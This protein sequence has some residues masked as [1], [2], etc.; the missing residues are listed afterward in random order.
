MAARVFPF[1]RFSGFRNFSGVQNR[2]VRGIVRSDCPDQESIM[3]LASVLMSLS[4]AMLLTLGT[5]HLVYTFH[6]PKLTPRDPAL[7]VSMSQVAP[8]ISKDM[9]MWQGWVG[10][11]ISHSMAALLFGLIYGF[12]AIAHPQLLFRSP[13]LLLVGLAMLGGLFVVGKVYWFRIPTAGIGMALLCYV[14]AVVASWMATPN[15]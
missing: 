14:A 10:F 2:R 4:A 5:L 11:N 9:T 13:F 15:P 12:L 3:R 1:T 6:G 7:R 8:V